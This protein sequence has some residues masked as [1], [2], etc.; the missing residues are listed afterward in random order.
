MYITNP[1]T[2]STFF[3]EKGSEQHKDLIQKRLDFYKVSAEDSFE[4][5]KRKFLALNSVDESYKS[6][7]NELNNPKKSRLTDTIKPEPNG[8]SYING[9]I[10]GVALIEV[11]DIIS[12]RYDFIAAEGSDFYTRKLYPSFT[13]FKQNVSALKRA[14][15]PLHRS[16]IIN[17]NLIDK[18]RLIKGG[19][20]IDEPHYLLLNNSQVY[21]KDDAS[22]RIGFRIAADVIGNEM[23][24][25]DKK[26]IKK[27]NKLGFYDR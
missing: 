12:G 6:K 19:S 9:V 17:S 16:Y 20:F 7:I 11:Y 8:P 2:D 14:E 24:K 18:C 21:H 26:R 1:Y 27:L 13:K 15:N 5:V 3:V 23:N 4:E 22:C 10:D 25:Y